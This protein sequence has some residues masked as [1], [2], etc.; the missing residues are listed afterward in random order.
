MEKYSGDDQP[1]D[2]RPTPDDFLNYLPWACSQLQLDSTILINKV[3]Q[4]KFVVT[5]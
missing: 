1:T 4:S 2:I 3:F 5:L